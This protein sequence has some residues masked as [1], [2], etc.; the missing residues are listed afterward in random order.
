MAEGAVCCFGTADGGGGAAH[1]QKAQPDDPGMSERLG[2]PGA[3]DGQCIPCDEKFSPPCLKCRTREDEAP[4]GAAGGLLRAGLSACFA[5]ASGMAVFRA[6]G[7]VCGAVFVFLSRRRA[8]AFCVSG[9][10]YGPVEIWRDPERSG[11]AGETGEA[12]RSAALVLRQ[13]PVRAS[14]KQRPRVFGMK[15]GT[16]PKRA[17]PVSFFAAGP[18]YFQLSMLQCLTRSRSSAALPS[19]KRSRVPTR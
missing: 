8:G 17:V 7:P 2:A 13:A 19:L 4:D 3:C 9:G 14:E 5:G 15:K 11:G 18:D 1:A 6:H 10:A 12:A 16:A